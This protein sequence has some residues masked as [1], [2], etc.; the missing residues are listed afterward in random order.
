MASDL[1]GHSLLTMLTVPG[2]PPPHEALGHPH[3]L[4]PLGSVM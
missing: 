1:L 4:L 2:M 3:N